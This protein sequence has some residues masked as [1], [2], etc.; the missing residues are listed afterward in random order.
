M[1]KVLRFVGLLVLP[2]AV[3]LAVT[4]CG[5]D[6]DSS[7]LDG[8]G[9]TEAPVVGNDGIVG[10]WEV[11]IRGVYDSKST[12]SIRDFN[13]Y[14][15]DKCYV[16]FGKNGA[17]TN[18]TSNENQR[19]AYSPSNES[20]FVI[21]QRPY[22]IVPQ[23]DGRTVVS[24]T[25]SRYTF[26]YLLTPSSAGQTASDDGQLLSDV[27]FVNPNTT[28]G[29]EANLVD[30]GLSVP[31]ADVNVG[32]DQ[33]DIRGKMNHRFTLSY[34]FVSW[35]DLQGTH[36]DEARYYYGGYWSEPTKEEFEEL[37]SKCK[38]T[39]T[40]YPGISIDC[41]LVTG[42]N[43]NRIYMPIG[44]YLSATQFYNI[45]KDAGCYT[46]DLT[47]TSRAIG[48]CKWTYIRTDKYE[49]PKDNGFYIRAVEKKQPSRISTATKVDLGIGTLWAG[50]N[51]GAS[52]P[53][54]IGKFVHWANPTTTRANRMELVPGTESDIVRVYMGNHWRIPNKEQA[55]ALLR[56]CKWD[57]ITLN[58][59]PGYKITGPNGSAIFLPAAGM[60][61]YDNLRSS[62]GFAYYW[63]A[64]EAESQ[65]ENR[66][67][68]TV[69]SDGRVTAEWDDFWLP[70]RPVWN[71]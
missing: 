65:Y 39:L 9:G 7:V 46:L 63:L 42:P 59:M 51:F 69:L 15:F 67:P 66:F 40:K 50:S 25:D 22:T 45:G 20:E 36:L 10:T 64:G 19:W 11:T 52:D 23:V 55:Y 54:E 18:H 5:D 32:G 12:R 38:W 17:F 16:T 44:R 71:M 8:G 41:Y 33:Q 60:Y 49:D 6:D 31:W 35:N 2:L 29:G 27:G 47:K 43:G 3:F 56:T 53:S 4:A 61:D 24:T 68:G 48:T 21:G 37:L 34:S 57:Y 14:L 70:V 1:V 13:A 58:G 30:L 26:Y 28:Y 62:V